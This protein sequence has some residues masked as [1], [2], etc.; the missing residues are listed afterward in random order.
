MTR[1]TSLI[2]RSLLGLATLALLATGVSSA[3]ATTSYTASLGTHGAARWTPGTSVY[4]NLKAMTPGTWKQQLWSGTCA[5]PKVRTAVLPS[6]VVPSSRVLAK[7]TST[8]VAP[9]TADGVVLRL[10][11]GSTVICGAFTK[12]ITVTPGSALHGNVLVGMEMAWTAFPQSSGP[13]P[14]TNYPVFDTRVID[15]LASKHVSVITFLFSWEGMQSQLNG[16]I[17]AATSGNYLAYFNNY[18]RIVAYATG[19]GIH[20]IVA[21]WQADADGG[22]AGPTWRGNLVGSPAVPVS[23]FTNFWSKMAAVFKDNPLV[24]YRLIT[25]PH[26]MSTMQ[27]WTTAQSTITAIRAAGATQR[28]LVP[29][30]DYAAASQWTDNWYDTAVPARSNAY[31]W[32]NAAGPGQPMSDPLNNTIAEVHTYLDADEG[33]VHADIT[34]VTAARQHLAV[35]VNEARAHGYQL[36]LGEIGMYAGTTTNDGHPASDAWHDFV[37]YANANTDVL[38]GWTWWAGGEPGWW[39]DVAAD[40]GGH[41]SITPT[42]GATFTGDTVNMTMIQGSF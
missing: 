9:R 11:L 29:G 31:G 34:S 36:F 20:V 1:P 18:K 4:V 32:L 6:L 28:I 39:D 25:E 41:Y 7:T 13:V 27:W 40:G 15:Y 12:P 14:D 21:P 10:L 23:A 2:R 8:S 30:T 26:D 35:A 22:I 38:L 42:N 17:P 16:P 19:L 5:A 24:W 3:A 33:G 37:S